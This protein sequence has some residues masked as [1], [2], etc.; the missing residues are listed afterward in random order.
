MKILE[1]LTVVRARRNLSQQDVA[2]LTGMTPA[3]I[4]RIEKGVSKPRDK[5]RRLIENVLDSPVDWDMTQQ[6]GF[7]KRKSRTRKH[8][9]NE[10]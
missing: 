9:N 5:T 7:V 4:N 6:Q 3:T 2:H 10:V 1:P 8:T